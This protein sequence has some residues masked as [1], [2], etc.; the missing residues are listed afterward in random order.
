MPADIAHTGRAARHDPASWVLPLAVAGGVLIAAAKL[1]AG[2]LALPLLSVL[3]IGA[4]FAVAVILLLTGS[5]IGQGSNGAWMAA[6]A[7]VFLGF[8]AALL[9]DGSEVLAQLERMQAHGTASAGN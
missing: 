4:G 9:S 8:A 2:P 7:L 5:R 6:G 1:L 3:L